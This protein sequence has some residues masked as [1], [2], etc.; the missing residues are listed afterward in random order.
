MTFYSTV[1]TYSIYIS[2]YFL[3]CPYL[4]F[5][6]ILTICTHPCL[7]VFLPAFAPSPLSLP[8]AVAANGA[9][10]HTAASSADNAAAASLPPRV[11]NALAATNSV[12]NTNNSINNN[13]TSN[14]TGTNQVIPTS[15]LVQPLVGSPL[16]PHSHPPHPPQSQSS[17]ATAAAANVSGPLAIVDVKHLGTYVCRSC[18]SVQSTA[19]S[20][21]YYTKLLIVNRVWEFDS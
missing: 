18:L 8:P 19:Q 5:V 10:G 3:H 13:G 1:G 20:T 4:L 11:N 9:S 2:H 17:T 7:F 12:V 14:S 15:T 6:V 16:H 21:I